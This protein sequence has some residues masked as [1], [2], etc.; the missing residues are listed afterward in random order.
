MTTKDLIQVLQTLDPDGER[1]I[2]MTNNRTKLL[3]LNGLEKLDLTSER[4]EQMFRCIELKT[5]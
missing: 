3:F 1:L 2:V 4:G 5:T